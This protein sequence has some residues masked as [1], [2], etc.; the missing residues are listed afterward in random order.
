MA[1]KNTKKKKKSSGSAEVK[2]TEPSD[3]VNP[4]LKE[5]LKQAGSDNSPEVQMRLAA[6]LRSAKLLVP[7]KVETVTLQSGTMKPVPVRRVN[8]FLLNTKDGSSFLPVFTDLEEME[9]SFKMEEGTEP[10][11]YTM[12]RV[13]DFLRKSAGRVG[14][15]VMNPGTQGHIMFPK[16]SVS[17]IAGTA[18]P[19]PQAAAQP[20][21]T[22]PSMPE[23]HVTYGEPAVYPT[24][25]DNAVYDLCRGIESVS[26]VWLK[27]KRPLRTIVLVVESDAKDDAILQQIQETAAPHA[28]EGAVEAVWYDAEAEEKIVQGAFAMYDREIDL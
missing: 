12:K 19:L 22:A 13:D 25:M 21:M 27:E 18:A 8:V 10:Q 15:M 20:A 4:E 9:K 17:V 26:R 6:A 5:I 2:I 1:K 11:I 14:G 7:A 16:E 23:V 3:V 28:K 24:R